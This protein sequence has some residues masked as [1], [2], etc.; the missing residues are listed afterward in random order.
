M[1]F[2]PVDRID[3]GSRTEVA[4]VPLEAVSIE[5]M[6]ASTNQSCFLSRLLQYEGSLASRQLCDRLAAVERTE[7]SL[8]CAC[9]LV[10][11]IAM[12]GFAGL[13]YGAVLLPQFFD[14]STHLV[15]RLSGAIGLGS[16]ACLLV[17]MG[18]WYSTRSAARRVRAECRT[19]VSKMLAERL[20]GF[21]EGSEAPVIRESPQLRVE[22]PRSGDESHSSKQTHGLL[23]NRAP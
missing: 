19:A 15:I 17:F 20:P 6:S 23:L 8:K 2:A 11:L 3:D 22:L 4:R 5:S 21:V 1:A 7:R 18:L 12:L 9:R 16:A 14:N 13:G 10:G